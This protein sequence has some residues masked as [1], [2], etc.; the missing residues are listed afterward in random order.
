[1]ALASAMFIAEADGYVAAIGAVVEF[2]VGEKPGT[3]NS[4][5]RVRSGDQVVIGMPTD[6]CRVYVQWGSAGREGRI[7]YDPVSNSLVRATFGP[8]SHQ[9][10]AVW[11]EEFQLSPLMNRV[12]IRAIS[13]PTLAH[14]QE[15]PSK[16]QI[17][18]SGQVTPS[19]ELIIIGPDG[20]V[21]G[22]YPQLLVIGQ[23]WLPQVAQWRPGQDIRIAP[24]PID[25]ARAEFAQK[26]AALTAR[27]AEIRAGI[28]ADR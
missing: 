28:N 23:A 17:I 10:P 13:D 11:P 20:P 5:R 25:Q 14:S 18:G 4:V 15:L 27:L 16:P 21:T 8:D 6:G 3:T 7:D 26:E 1:M 12:G 24:I 19:G 2:S 22:G 9:F